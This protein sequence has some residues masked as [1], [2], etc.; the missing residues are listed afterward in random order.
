V[1]DHFKFYAIFNISSFFAY[2]FLFGTYVHSENNN[3]NNTLQGN[4]GREGV[5]RKGGNFVGGLLNV[6]NSPH[7]A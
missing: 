1:C 5:R 2:L 4:S 6:G 7:R 3:R